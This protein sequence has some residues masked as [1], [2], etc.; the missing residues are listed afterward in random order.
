M[1]RRFGVRCLIFLDIFGSGL[2]GVGLFLG[3]VIRAP[4]VFAGL[5]LLFGLA[6]ADKITLDEIEATRSEGVLMA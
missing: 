4:S 3:A 2:V 1:V 6:R 5:W